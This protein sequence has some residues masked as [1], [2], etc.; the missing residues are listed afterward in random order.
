MD[1]DKWIEQL[2]DCKYLDERQMGMLCSR[3]INILIEESNVQVR[4]ALVFCSL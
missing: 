4:K 1:L 2:W 3:L